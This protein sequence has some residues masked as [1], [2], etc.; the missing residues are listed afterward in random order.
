MIYESIK[1]GVLEQATRRFADVGTWPQ[2]FLMWLIPSKARWIRR[3]HLRNSKE[4]ALR[5]MNDDSEHKDFLWYIM[6]QREKKSEVSDNEVIINA[7]LFM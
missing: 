1:A 2:Q 7:A 6:K 4:K 5:R 3:E